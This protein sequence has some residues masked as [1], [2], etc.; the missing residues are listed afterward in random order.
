MRKNIFRY[1]I[2]NIKMKTDAII[3]E[4]TLLNF[5]LDILYLQSE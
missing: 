4:S 1:L 3:V 2:L 5:N